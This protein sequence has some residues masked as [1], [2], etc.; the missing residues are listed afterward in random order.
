MFASIALGIA[1]TDLA[2]AI[3]GPFGARR[4]STRRRRVAW[5]AA[6]WASRRALPWSIPFAGVTAVLAW[7]PDVQL[8]LTAFLAGTTVVGV[9]LLV[10]AGRLE[11]RGRR[12]VALV[13]ARLA[14]QIAFVAAAAFALAGALAHPVPACSL[15][16]GGWIALLAG[17]SGKPRPAGALALALCATGL[18]S[19]LVL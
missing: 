9:R 2:F 8:S 11:A 13:L 4:A 15:A 19:L 16:L 5:L 17:L 10:Q 7:H 18:A 12:P 6:T 14:G 1:L 3:A